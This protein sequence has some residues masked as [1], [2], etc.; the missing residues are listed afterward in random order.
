MI[1]ML[2]TIS[3]DEA[4][5]I[6]VWF[7]E[8]CNSSNGRSLISVTFGITYFIIVSVITSILGLVIFYTGLPEAIMAI[9]ICLGIVLAM[10]GILGFNTWLSYYGDYCRSKY[11]TDSWYTMGKRHSFTRIETQI[12]HY[13]S[14]HRNYPSENMETYLKTW[15]AKYMEEDD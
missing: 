14:G 6:K 1:K 11:G 2:P 9:T 10:G 15:F 13:N 4:S 3:A 12:A 8:T 7:R 5:R